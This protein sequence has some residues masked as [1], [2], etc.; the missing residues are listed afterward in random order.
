MWVRMVSTA[1]GPRLPHCLNASHVYELEDELGAELVRERAAVEVPNPKKAAAVEAAADAGE[2]DVAEGSEQKSEKGDD[3]KKSDSLME[4][5]TSTEK[6]P[7]KS[8]GKSAAKK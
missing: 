2:K 7:E 5:L 4:K 8:A 3:G 1:A 6:A